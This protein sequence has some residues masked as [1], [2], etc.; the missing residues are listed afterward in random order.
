[1]N[2]QIVVAVFVVALSSLGLS[3]MS[4]AKDLSY[5]SNASKSDSDKPYK[6]E[7]YSPY[8]ERNFP[9]EPLWGDTHVHTTMSL[10]A[11]GWK[12]ILSPDDAFR[13]AKGEELISTGG[14]PV[15]LSRP[16]DWL[17]VTDHSDAMGAMNE[18]VAGNPELMAY[19]EIKAWHEQINKGGQ[20]GSDAVVEVARTFI[21]G[22][23]PK[24]LLEKQFLRNIWQQSTA[25]A[26]STNEPGLFSAII[27]Y[28]WTSTPNGNN[29][30]RNV[31]FRDGA[32]KANKVLPF[33]VAESFN[34]EDLWK[35]LAAYEE[36]T[37]GQVMA[38][39]HNANMSNGLMF[40][41]INPATGKAITA[42]Y[43]KSRI[44][45]EPLYEVTQIKGDGEAHPF[46]SPIDEFADYETWDQGNMGPDPKETSMFQFEYAREALKNGLKYEAQLGTNPYKFGLQGATDSHTG[47]ATAEENN[48]FG[49][50]S[51]TE[52]SPT[53]WRTPVGR[54]EDMVLTGWSQVS[55][56]YSAV[57]ATENTREAI[58]DAMKRKEIYATTGP[59]INLRFFGGWNFEDS[60]ALV[61][62]LGNVGYSK[63]VP[64][65]GDLTSG[66][67]GRAPSFLIGAKR[68]PL[69]GNLDRIQVIKGWLDDKGNTREKVYEAAWSGAR[70]LDNEGKLAAVGN[71]VNVKNA[72]WR[73]T[74]GASELMTV[75][76]DPDFDASQRAFYY[77]RVIEIPTP[78]WTAYEANRY[79]VEMDKSIPMITQER[80]Y[81]SPIWYTP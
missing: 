9:V 27:G 22:K 7:T 36:K 72:T 58:F 45:W 78:R 16:L 64:M 23:T 25:A 44:R 76:S 70:A 55:S 14:I 74:I 18:I 21:G 77:A 46:L 19:P 33:T 53:R 79:E 15:R 17:V 29:L 66:P 13:F 73:N 63:G 24:V 62:E 81:S 35:W 6:T 10:D 11:R 12:V 57:W 32:D 65:G 51:A 50:H 56:G 31:I 49:K 1:M 30:H 75:W 28:E 47:L 61:R 52:P 2:T 54:I 41:D 80:A 59:R 3:K 42:K 60:D 39:A 48:Y 67:W 5:V 71:T 40:P 26:D 43:A 20:E 37:G 4:S 69:S 8:A 68:D 38:I 34:P